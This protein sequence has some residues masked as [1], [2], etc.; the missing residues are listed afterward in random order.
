VLRAYFDERGTHAGSRIMTF[1]G[2]V[3]H[4]DDWERFAT[5]ACQNQ[6][7]CTHFGFPRCSK[8]ARAFKSRLR[9]NHS[10]SPLGAPTAPQFAVP[11]RCRPQI[12][13]AS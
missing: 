1:A 12:A 6:R 10:R 13:V 4:E 5:A 11:I 7:S 3:A 9:S 2:Y 8:D